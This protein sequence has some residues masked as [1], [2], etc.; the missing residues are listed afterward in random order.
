MMN[1]DTKTLY[2]IIPNYPKGSTKPFIVKLGNKNT[3]EFELKE[4]AKP[5]P[6]KTKTKTPQTPEKK[7]ETIK[8][9][10]NIY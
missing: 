2:D 7:Q 10:I 9:Q 6:V 3:W 1:K 8:E 4:A 5:V